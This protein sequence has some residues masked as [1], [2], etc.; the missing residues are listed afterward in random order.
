[1]FWSIDLSTVKTIVYRVKFK[2]AQ[3]KKHPPSRQVFLRQISFQRIIFLNLL[4]A[5]PIKPKPSKAIV[6]GS[7]TTTTDTAT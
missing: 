5:K 6:E 2:V 3:T 1:M 7:G 4:E